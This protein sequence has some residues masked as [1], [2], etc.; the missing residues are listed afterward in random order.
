M[1]GSQA[2]QHVHVLNV[3][4]NAEWTHQFLVPDILTHSVDDTPYNPRH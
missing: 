3:D 4:C 2:L 1:E